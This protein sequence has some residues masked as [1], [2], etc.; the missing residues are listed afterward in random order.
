MIDAYPEDFPLSGRALTNW[1]RTSGL[2]FFLLPGSG[3]DVRRYM[4]SWGIDISSS[5][6]YKIRNEIL[7]RFEHTTDLRSY[8]PSSLIPA[9][10]H[11]DTH[12]LDL[13][14]KFLYRI[15]VTGFDPITGGA[16][17]QWYAVAS[18][19]QMTSN[20]ASDR[21]G[22]LLTGEEEGY[23]MVAETFIVTEALARP[24]TW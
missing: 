3:A 7:S 21:L 14:S 13:G 2:G 12:G 19:N 23:R 6:F 1:L 8:D 5:T 9:A 4:S 15:N 10:W 17:S 18:A 24:G 20:Q 16:T 11:S 22:S